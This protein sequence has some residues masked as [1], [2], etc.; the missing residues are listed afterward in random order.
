MVDFT[1]LA[2]PRIHEDTFRGILRR[3]DSPAAAEAHDAYAEIVAHGV[4]PALAL[5]VFQHESS[6]GR[7]GAAVPHRNWGNL[8]HSPFFK[9]E[10]GFVC[11]PTWHD[12]AG[13]TAR[14]LA[15]YGRNLIRPRRTT[16]TARTFPHVWA[17]SSDGNA[18]TRY[19]RAIVAAM[20]GF[21]AEDRARHPG[22]VPSDDHGG[23]HRHPEPRPPDDQS[24]QTAAHGHAKPVAAGGD[25]PAPFVTILD[26]SRIRAR[27]RLDASVLRVVHTGVHATVDRVRSGAPY[28]VNGAHANTWL[29][30]RAINGV[31][32]PRPVFSASILWARQGDD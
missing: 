32:L 20:Q 16:C 25:L 31:A 13:D 4:D 14:L 19:G 11:Y 26:R 30:I 28:E 3:H 1:I 22:S 12:G 9:S 29:R 24:D 10:A 23:P 8:R 2:K 6:F 15:I 5:A 17:P 7:A 21:I 27:P 18:P